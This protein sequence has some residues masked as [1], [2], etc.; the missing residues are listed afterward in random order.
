MGEAPEE[1]RARIEHKRDEIGY[2]LDALG[3]RMSPGR[4]AERKRAEYRYRAGQ[5]WQAMRTRVMGEDGPTGNEAWPP[6]AS[7]PVGMATSGTYGAYGSAG[8]SPTGGGSVGRA[9]GNGEP[10]LTERVGS[11]MSNVTGTIGDAVTDAPDVVRR[12]AR[13][14]PLAVGLIS[15]G[16]GLVVAALLPE[17]EAERRAVEHVQPQL[18][19]LGE[20]VADAG[21]EV[22]HGLEGP[23]RDAVEQTTGA[24]R[25]AAE[26]VKDQTREAATELREEATRA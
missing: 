4:I 9:P 15:F 20:T 13:G 5:R 25:D 18:E 2:D 23:A 12:R 11:T 14:A 10:G 21:R 22:A 6:P 1:L 26:Q 8:T 19:Q 3:D 16:V 24:V 7:R 17:S